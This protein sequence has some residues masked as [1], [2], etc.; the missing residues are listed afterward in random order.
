MSYANKLQYNAHWTVSCNHLSWYQCS[1]D[2]IILSPKQKY[3]TLILLS[4]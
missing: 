4:P 3:L 1:C 2:H